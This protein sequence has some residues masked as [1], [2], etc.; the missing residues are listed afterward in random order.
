MDKQINDCS[1][2]DDILDKHHIDVVVLA[3]FMQIIP[4]NIINK[5]PNKIINIHHGFLPAFK[6]AR[7]YRQAYNKGVKLIGATAHYVTEELDEGPIIYQDVININHKNSVNDLIKLGREIEKTV[8]YR[9]VK[10]HLEHKIIV[11]DNKT[12]VFD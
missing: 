8:L 5:Y 3:R 6:G 7:P 12:I 1:N 9:S 11:H 10:S 4:T 2:L